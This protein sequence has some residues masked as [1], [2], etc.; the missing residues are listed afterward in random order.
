VRGI[1][2]Q[3]AYSGVHVVEARTGPIER[4]VPAIVKSALQQQVLARLEENK[5]YSGGKKSH[6]YLL[7]GLVA[8]VHC[9]TAYIGDTSISSMGYRYHYYA[10]RKKRETSDKKN[11]GL[12]CPKVKAGWLEELVWADVRSFLENPG[13]VLERVREQFAEDRGG[14]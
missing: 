10:C 4:R 2:R 8:C 12:P 1:V 6:N 5:R 14:E 9:G 3:S 7:R 13:E 11:R